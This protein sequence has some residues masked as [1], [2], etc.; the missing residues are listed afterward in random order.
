MS[1]CY[2]GVRFNKYSLITIAILAIISITLHLTFPDH[3]IVA[4]TNKNVQIIKNQ[5]NS[6][7]L[8]TYSV[9]NTKQFSLKDETGMIDI[10]KY[11]PVVEE[12]TKI[13][14]KTK[15]EEETEK[16]LA[17]KINDENNNVDRDDELTVKITKLVLVTAYSSTV[18]QC[19][20]TPFITANG[21]HVHDGTIA[22]NFLEFGTKVRFPSLY[23]DKVF[24][25]ED[26]MK[27]DYKVDIWFP[28]RQEAIN[29]GAKRVEIEI[30]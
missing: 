18:D 2:S 11:I 10:E 28:T 14:E 19:D 23:G 25:V 15:V 21:T 12:K 17:I 30:L 13:E 4:K 8:E 6:C 26:R 22:A 3:S 7:D 9:F 27:S 16:V 29:F 5:T 24:I 20:S 1:K